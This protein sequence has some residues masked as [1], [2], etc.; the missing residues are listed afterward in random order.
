[1]SYRSRWED[2]PLDI[3]YEQILFMDPLD[4][5]KICG[6]PYVDEKICQNKNGTIWKLLFQRDLSENLPI[7]KGEETFMDKYMDAIQ[8]SKTLSIVELLKYGAKNGYDKLVKEIKLLHVRNYYLLYDPFLLATENGHLQIVKFFMENG[9]NF[10]S[11]VLPSAIKNGHLEIVKYL[12]EN[13]ANV[14]FDRGLA[15]R[16]AAGNG[17]LDMVKY[18]IEHGADVHGVIGED[19][20]P[21]IT[22]S[23]KGHLP[24][25]KYLIENGAYV[26]ANNGDA[27]RSAA[28]MGHLEVV[29][30][31][32]ENGANVHSYGE[33]ALRI[34]AENGHLAV[35]KLLIENGANVQVALNA[36]RRDRNTN[37]VR[38]LENI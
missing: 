14:N 26:N 11:Q 20:E 33:Y 7:L 1:M 19:Y 28:A 25:V 2:L 10:G 15:L 32:V 29:K 31:L 27:I 37:V 16:T 3:L 36:A 34:A 30:S 4:I 6:D 12:V 23:F 35:A 38:I 13:G 22:A 17:N 9:A 24:V 18:L 5:L 21:L 8:K